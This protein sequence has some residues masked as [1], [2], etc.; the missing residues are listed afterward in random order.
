LIHTHT[1]ATHQTVYTTA[2]FF[3]QCY[4]ESYLCCF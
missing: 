4:S 1:C 3:S 2:M